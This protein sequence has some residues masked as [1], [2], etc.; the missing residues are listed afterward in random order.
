[1]SVDEI[2]AIAQAGNGHGPVYRNQAARHGF[3]DRPEFQNLFESFES[4]ARDFPQNSC[5]GWRPTKRGRS[6]SYRWLSYQETLQRV[7]MCG[8]GLAALGL[9]ASERIG[10]LGTNSKDLMITM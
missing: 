8:S 10:T 3:S 2:V 6:G 4:A 7:E 1:M 5:L 9:D